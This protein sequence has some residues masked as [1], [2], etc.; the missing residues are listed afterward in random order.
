V[1]VV[2]VYGPPFNYVPIGNVV[3]KGITIRGNQ[4]SVKRLLPRLID[5]VQSGRLNPKG[6]ITH[7]IPLEEVAD[8]YRLFSS[9]LDNCIKTVLIP[10]AK[11]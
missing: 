9:K 3:N 5:H 8:A 6:L 10:S 2:G 4:A 1:S 7:R 11:H